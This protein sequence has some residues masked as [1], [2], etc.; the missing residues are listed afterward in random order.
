MEPPVEAEALYRVLNLK[1]KNGA[2]LDNS[3]AASVAESVSSNYSNND[4]ANNNNNSYPTPTLTMASSSGSSPAPPYSTKPSIP[5]NSNY[6][7]NNSSSSTTPHRSAPPPP[8]PPK[9]RK[10]QMATALYAFS[11]ERDTDLSFGKG[12]VIEVVEKTDN[13]NEW[14][15][16]RLNGKQGEFPGTYVKV[17]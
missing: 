7:N 12:D 6:N 16:G 17:M 13:P 5:Y 3:D 1:F 15:V 8:V 4:Y 10:A 2:F 14:W 9:A 11:G